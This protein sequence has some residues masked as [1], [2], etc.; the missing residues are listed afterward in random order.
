MFDFGYIAQKVKNVI[1]KYLV[2]KVANFIFCS[3]ADLILFKFILNKEHSAS[4]ASIF[5]FASDFHCNNFSDVLCYFCSI[6][7]AAIS[8]CSIFLLA[9]TFSSS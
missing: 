7:A 6:S 9:K 4:A 1:S 8:S 5:L 3:L 2:Q